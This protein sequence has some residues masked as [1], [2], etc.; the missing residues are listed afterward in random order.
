[1]VKLFLHEFEGLLERRNEALTYGRSK[2]LSQLPPKTLA[3]PDKNLLVGF[4][5]G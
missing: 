1:V 2:I 4:Y 3:S 5:D